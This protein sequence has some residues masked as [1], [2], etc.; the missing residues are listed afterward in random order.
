MSLR[1]RVL[2]GV[3]AVAAVLVL[4]N[5]AL[6]RTFEADL[7]G[8]VDRDLA[9]T[10]ARPA[11]G[12]RPGRGGPRPGDPQP[13]TDLFIADVDLTTGEVARR[14][15]SIRDLTPPDLDADEVAAGGAFTVESGDVP[16]RFVTRSLRTGNVLVVGRPIDDVE[17][18]LDRMRLVQVAG[19][20]AV[21]AALAA[22]AWWVLRLGVRPVV[23]MAAT[24]DE[25]AAGGDLARRVAHPDERTE[26]GRLGAAFNAM[27]GRIEEAFRQREAS[28]ARVR[29]FAADASHELRTPLTSIRGY[30]E[31]WEAGGLRGE[32]ELDEAMRRLA[33]EGARMG[34]MVEDLLLLARL[35]EHRD[36]GRTAVRLDLLAEDGVADARAVE[37][38]RPIAVDVAPVTVEGDEP[39]LRQIVANLLAN[40]RVHT[41]PGT[42][43]SVSVSADGGTA[44]LV[45]A[46]EGPGMA[47]DEAERA[48]ERF[49]R[50]DPSRA[51]ARG[52]SGLGLSIVA[53]VAEAHGGRATVESAPGEGARF[54]VELPAP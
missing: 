7:L 36:L 29:R 42:P 15:S 41:P 50:A 14:G 31:L 21:L 32:G 30:A 37:P 5:L 1:R 33:Q 53:A 24:A 13:L 26:A 17:D 11:V 10:S 18:T 38:D 39:Q 48:F 9:E 46:D 20:A 40:A 23:S 16:W 43:V 51:R 47:P 34:A 2:L 12:G 19:S 25:I 22:V 54:V 3:A 35:D 4:T 52:G 45:V 49:Y 44:R 28:E 8:R 6:S 27:L